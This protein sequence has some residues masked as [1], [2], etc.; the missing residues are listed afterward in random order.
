VVLEAMGVHLQLD[1]QSIKNWV[2][3]Y[4]DASWNDVIA[5]TLASLRLGGSIALTV[6]G[7]MVLIPLLL[8]YFLMDQDDMV[9]RLGEWVPPRYKAELMA[10]FADVDHL[11]GQYLRGQLGVMLTMACYYSAA[12]ALVGLKLALPIGLLTGLMLFIP[13]IG[14]GTGFVLALMS[15]LIQFEPSYAVLGVGLV[16]A[17]GQGMEGFF[18]TPRLVGERIGLHPVMV[19]FALLFAAQAV[20]LVGVMIALPV[21]AVLSVAVRWLKKYYLKSAFFG[22]DHC[23]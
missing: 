10:F 16:Y 8:F 22:H 3:N 2:T 4:V 14:I 23:A 19:I 1:A 6:L 12:L 20:G 9:H 15:A 11:L 17:M 21:S 5:Q 13:Y 18:L 7:N